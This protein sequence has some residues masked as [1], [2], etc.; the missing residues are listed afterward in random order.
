[1]RHITDLSLCQQSLKT[2]V[3]KHIVDAELQLPK[4]DIFLHFRAETA[5]YIIVIHTAEYRIWSEP[6]I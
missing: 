3:I 1:M 2:G 6:L 4:R 5:A